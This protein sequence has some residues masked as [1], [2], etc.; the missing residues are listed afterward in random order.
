MLTR[1]ICPTDRRGV[2]TDVTDA[3]AHLLSQA[4]PTRDAALAEV[5]GSIVDDRLSP[6][7][8]FIEADEGEA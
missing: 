5:L 6:L 2:Y 7:V 4:L 1:Y 8:R 3:G